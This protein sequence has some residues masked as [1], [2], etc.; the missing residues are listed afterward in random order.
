M[1]GVKRH[2]DCDEAAGK[3]RKG[4]GMCDRLNTDSLKPQGLLLWPHKM[5]LAMGRSEAHHYVRTRFHAV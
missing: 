3:E 4:H 2:L 1:S 5:E